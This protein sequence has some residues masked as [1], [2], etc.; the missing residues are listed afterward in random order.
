MVERSPSRLYFSVFYVLSQE[1]NAQEK[2]IIKKWVGLGLARPPVATP[3]QLSLAQA[4]SIA[5]VKPP[6]RLLYVVRGIFLI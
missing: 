5:Y 3:L 2:F 4:A 6:S 1:E